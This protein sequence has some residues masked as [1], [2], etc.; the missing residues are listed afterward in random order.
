MRALFPWCLLFACLI[1]LA[2]IENGSA[3]LG[4]TKKEALL[5]ITQPL[6]GGM[7]SPMEMVR[8]KVSGTSRQIYLLVHPMLSTEWWVQRKPSPPNR[9]GSWRGLAQFGEAGKH[10]GYEF[11]LVALTTGVEL[12]EGDRLGELPTDGIRSDIIAVRRKD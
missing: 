2:A 8:G 3:A 6:D 4:E 10:H 9:D 12:K 11:E 1:A 7:V 5:T